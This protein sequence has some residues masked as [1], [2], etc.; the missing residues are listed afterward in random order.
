MTLFFWI[1]GRRDWLA[2]RSRSGGLDRIRRVDRWRSS[3]NAAPSV[4]KRMQ[5]QRNTIRLNRDT[6]YNANANRVRL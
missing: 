1:E 2:L 5:F 6:S 3:S 4:D